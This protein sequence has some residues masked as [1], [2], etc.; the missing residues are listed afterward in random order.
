MNAWSV[1][2]FMIFGWDQQPQ[3]DFKIATPRDQGDLVLRGGVRWNLGMWSSHPNSRGS[4]LHRKKA[5]N[6]QR[7]GA[8]EREVSRQILTTHSQ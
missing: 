7:E 6:E 2:R 4:R 8:C 1:T 5:T 3:A